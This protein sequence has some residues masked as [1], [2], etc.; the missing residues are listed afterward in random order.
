MAQGRT[1][2]LISASLLQVAASV[3][4]GHAGEPVQL[5]PATM[6]TGGD[7]WMHSAASATASVEGRA[8]QSG[9]ILAIQCDRSDPRGRKLI[10]AA[11]RQLN[12]ASSLRP[13]R[14]LRPDSLKITIETQSTRYE[15]TAVIEER[16]RLLRGSQSNAVATY[17]SPERLALIRSARS[18]S[19]MTGE[20]EYSFTGTG[21]QVAT[22][23]LTCGSA[24][25]TRARRTIAASATPSTPTIRT[26]WRFTSLTAS[27]TNSVGNRYSATTSTLGFAESPIASFKVEITCRASRLFA[28]FANGTA[29]NSVSG[30]DKEAATVFMNGITAKTNVAK[31]YKASRI[32]A[33]FPVESGPAR[34]GYPLST[35]DLAALMDFDAV[36]VSA[37]GGGPTI[38]FSGAGGPHAI[39]AL[40]ETCGTPTS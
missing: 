33:T 21:S 25:P 38:E 2:T 23:A 1:G 35:A 17:L 12:P 11:T 37:I 32:V 15:F 20:R 10:F 7:A 3:P 9:T 31:V 18:I 36:R 5:L 26:A 16:G 29:S 30:P 40:A 27:P 13:V 6:Q 34:T 14:D 24:S 28:V 8:N 4:P 19:I 22:Q 39:A